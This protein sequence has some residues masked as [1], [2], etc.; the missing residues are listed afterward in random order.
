MTS[1]EK[2]RLVCVVCAAAAVLGCDEQARGGAGTASA[3]AAA[4]ASAKPTANQPVKTAAA[5][6]PAAPP[7]QC[8][9]G[10]SGK[11]TAQDACRAKGAKR[12]LEVT[13]AGNDHMGKSEFKIKN[14]G[15]KPITNASFY[16]FFYDKD[17]KQ[18]DK[19]GQKGAIG[20]AGSIDALAP[21]A[22]ASVDLHPAK[23]EWP[24]NTVTVEAEAVMVLLDDG[25]WLQND[26]L[27][28]GPTIGD[29]PKGGIK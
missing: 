2:T 21:G 29:R 7:V 5:T 20:R 15:P 24:P 26:D 3:T 25:A 4:T 8:P 1:M 16:T 22:T 27:I 10:T 14:V 11:G 23:A 17:G 18:L 19:D 9:E 28:G 6:P 13:Y 12:W